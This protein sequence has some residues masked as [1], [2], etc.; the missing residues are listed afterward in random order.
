MRDEITAIRIDGKVIVV[1]SV[2]PHFGGE[3]DFLLQDCELR[4]QWHG[5]RFD[6]ETGTCLSHPVNTKV[7]HYE[8]RAT[9]DGFLEI[10]YQ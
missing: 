4:C 6:L 8:Y 3:F 5:W 7:R 10:L 2:C 9:E 1:S